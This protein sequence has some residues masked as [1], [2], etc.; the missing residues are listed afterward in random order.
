MAGSPEL[1]NFDFFAGQKKDSF[2]DNLTGME[3]MLLNER[4]VNNIKK[5]C[6]LIKYHNS[7]HFQIWHVP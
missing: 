4:L 6:K 2:K 1:R 7:I 5:K 3:G